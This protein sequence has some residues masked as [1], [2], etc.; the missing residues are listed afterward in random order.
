MP[1]IWRVHAVAERELKIKR[2][3]GKD[4][5]TLRDRG[6]IPAPVMMVGQVWTTEQWEELQ[7]KLKDLH[8]SKPGGP[9]NSV[10]IQNPCAAFLGI[11]SLYI[12]KIE[13]PDVMA[14]G[15]ATI[16]IEGV[17]WTVKPKTVKKRREPKITVTHDTPFQRL[18]D[19]TLQVEIISLPRSVPPSTD[20]IV[21]LPFE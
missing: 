17:Q 8:P 20:P 11:T 15:K 18:P 2:A 21:F 1:G 9:R 16:R 13:S 3:R 19:G 7:L 5:G 6:Y 14:N 10:G 4:L 12:R